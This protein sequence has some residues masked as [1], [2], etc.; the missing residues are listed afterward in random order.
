MFYQFD[1][2]L[3]VQG[4]WVGFVSVLVALFAANALVAHEPT[5]ASN[6]VAWTLAA[7]LLYALAVVCAKRLHDLGA[8][9]RWLALALVPPAAA[10]LFAGLARMSGA[11][12]DG[13]SGAA[14][15]AIHWGY[16]GLFLLIVGTLGLRA[17][18]PNANAYG[19]SPVALEL[20]PG[21]DVTPAEPT[22]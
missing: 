21:H 18:D 3:G 20:E 8:S 11:D 13:I 15:W 2:R 22:A 4:F 14:R 16:G 19:P 10:F 5:F 17:G 9:A 7:P 1:G 6:W 12:L